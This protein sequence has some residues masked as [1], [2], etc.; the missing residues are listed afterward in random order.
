[1]LA[2]RAS[3]AASRGDAIVRR[4]LRLGGH[5][6]DGGVLSFEEDASSL[7][8]GFPADTFLGTNVVLGNA[9]YR[10]PLAW[11]ERGIGTWP[12]F[13]RAVHVTGFLD[14]GQA[15]TGRFTAADAK[16][17]WGVEAGADVTA[18]YALPFTW[19]VGVGWGRDLS[20]EVADNREIY[21][22]IGRGF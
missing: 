22:R 11:I 1:M 15:W 17:S 4:T 12:L 20:N 19:I 10:V 21:I 13:L 14:A 9:E 6:T 2:L 7:L 8:R 18:G 5:G 16:L 3:G